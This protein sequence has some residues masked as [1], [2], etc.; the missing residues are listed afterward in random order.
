MKKIVQTMIAITLTS[1]ALICSACSNTEGAETTTVKASFTNFSGYSILS[2]DECTGN[3]DAGEPEYMFLIAG[4]EAVDVNGPSIDGTQ[5]CVI[6]NPSVTEVKPGYFEDEY[7]SG[8]VVILNP[9]LSY[10]VEIDDFESE[11]DLAEVRLSPD[12]GKTSSEFI[13][14]AAPGGDGVAHDI[15]I[16]A[17]VDDITIDIKT[18][19]SIEVR[20]SLQ[21]DISTS[22][23]RLSDNEET[24]LKGGELEELLFTNFAFVL[25][26]DS[27]V[28]IGDSNNT[29]QAYGKTAT[30]KAFAQA[31]SK[32][33]CEANFFFP[34]NDISNEIDINIE[35]LEDGQSVLAS[36]SAGNFPAHS[37]VVI[38]VNYGDGTGY[39]A[40][41]FT[42]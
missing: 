14:I 23:L 1:S 11:V 21:G 30:V 6:D 28:S 5:Y 10:T 35:G 41:V 26:F 32:E 16:T 37:Q 27:A 40:R 20:G 4:E 25:G 13:F 12:D 38:H 42:E 7:T 36:P 3:P 29:I 9:N 15:T 18:I 31:G 2:P 39:I 22:I 17:I 24:L 19:G 34:E 8:F 33:E